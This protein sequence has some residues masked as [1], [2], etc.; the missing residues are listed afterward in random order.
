MSAPRR[1]ILTLFLAFVIIALVI[2]ARASYVADMS[3]FL[4]QSPSPAQRLL[5]QQLQDGP[6]SRLVLIGI[7]GGDA[8]L[9]AR[10][11]RALVQSLRGHSQFLLVSNGE[12]GVREQE[13][14]RFVFE[15]RYVLSDDVTSERFSEA[16]LETVIG[17]NLQSM[18]ATVGLSAADLFQSD[19]T[20][21]TM[22]VVD[23]LAGSTQPARTAG[24]WSSKDGRRALLLLQTAASGSDTDAQE[25][26]L[27]V[28]H[29]A[30]VATDTAGL[31]LLVSSPGK[32][33]V[34]ARA[35]IKR[36]A[37][38][39]S[40]LSAGLIIALLW[41]AYR[42][43]RALLF[44]LLPVVSG[45]LAGIACV[46]LGFG[47]V[48]GI[49]LGFGVTLIGESV[50]YS[51]YLLVQARGGQTRP[52]AL[53]PTMILGA[54]TSIC[55]FASLLPSAFPGLAQLGLFSIAGL[56]AAAL[57][58]RFVLPALLPARLPMGDLTGVGSRAMHGFRR[59]IPSAAATIAIAL[60]VA[61]ITVGI[62]WQSGDRLWSR[63][64]STLSPVPMKLQRLDTELRADL[65]APDI[66][67][68]IVVSASDEQSVLQAAE[69][70]GQ[71]LDPLVAAGIMSGYDSPSHYLP[72]TRT[73]LQRQGSLPD[74]ASLHRRIV[75]VSQTLGLQ[76]DALAAF[77]QQIADSRKAPPITR[78]ML[79]GT[80]LAL[81]LSGL[82]WQHDGTWHGVLPLRAILAGPHAGDI[83][84]DR[85]RSALR[86]L[87]EQW[88]ALNIKHETDSLYAGYLNAVMR[89]SGVGL[90]A[91]V[92][93]LLITLRNVVR[94][95]RV[96]AALILAVLCVLAVLA[97]LHVQLGILHL[98]GLLLI[99]AVGSNYAL[100]F[101]RR[102]ADED[103]EA[104]PLTLAS[105][106]LA[107]LCTV[108]GFGVLAFSSVPVLQALGSTVAPGTLLALVFSAALAP[109]R[110]W[111]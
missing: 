55:G 41:W 56:I 63:D 51:V 82:L 27:A 88:L 48:H 10:A 111:D 33:A 49:T 68:L 23:Q 106:L 8:T 84:L 81:G 110:L 4:P 100:F 20:G 95:L 21:E 94:V 29:A 1:A 12:N 89:L 108:I 58:T 70:I 11:S 96:L 79:Q 91:I 26:A 69:A 65:G 28:I 39:L 60:G 22:Q 66:G 73:Q 31:E 46:Q 52:G 44:G 83:D 98:V 38:R 30:W 57:V 40:L 64:I 16:S 5:V 76:R 93:L 53:W 72:S 14:E 97:V 101:D 34:D 15:H 99:V 92:V 67:S 102:A 7:Q 87:P 13:E 6:A 47:L 36:E 17:D 25:Q 3:A 109:R 24:V 107:N 85:V 61:A 43:V 78:S 9:R 90:A 86:D 32:F 105:L 42:S 80:S 18:S 74:A 2:V 62:V 37:T 103:Q 59:V 75:Q 50:D 54:L 45:A 104:L 19:P 77:E 35:T 71:R